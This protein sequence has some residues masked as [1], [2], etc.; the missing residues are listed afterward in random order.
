[1]YPSL[2]LWRPVSRDRFTTGQAHLLAVAFQRRAL[3][4]E[5]EQC[6]EFSQTARIK[7]VYHDGERIEVVQ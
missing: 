3:I 6:I 4:V 2:Q 7:L 1:M 5:V